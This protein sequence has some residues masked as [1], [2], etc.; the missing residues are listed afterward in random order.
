M[1][2]STKARYATRILLRMARGKHDHV[3]RKQDLADLEGMPVDYVGQIL[4]AIKRAGYVNSIRGIQGGFVLMRNP[5]DLTLAEVVEATDGP[6]C[7]V[8]CSDRRAACD[9]SA[10]CAVQGVWEE[11]S[12]VLRDYLRGVTIGE[13]VR[14]TEE[15]ERG[16]P[17][18]FDI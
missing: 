16:K 12:H 9:R 7:L 11:A 6:I 5:A 15:L 17:L 8:P 18:E 13:L 3:W 1:Q 10:T 2:F 14:R 4:L